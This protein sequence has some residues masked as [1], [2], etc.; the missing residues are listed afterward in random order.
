MRYPC[1][2]VGALVGWMLMFL[3]ALHLLRGAIALS[4]FA[5]VPAILMLVA[6]FACWLPA[7][8]ATAVDVMV[9]LRQD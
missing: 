8:R 7:H 1:Q 6:A 3:V 9:A 5:G 2:S 4:V